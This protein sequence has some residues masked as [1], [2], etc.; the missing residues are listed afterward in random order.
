MKKQN[1][2]IVKL[3]SPVCWAFGI[4]TLLALIAFGALSKASAQ[5]KGDK[6]TKAQIR[7]ASTAD[8]PPPGR[9]L[10]F[11]KTITRNGPATPEVCDPG[12]WATST[13][14]PAAR[15]RAG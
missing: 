15:Y 13:T 1:A 2:I 5:P 14:G 3:Q 10:I 7:S 11:A 9:I 4:V 12:T 6:P 8:S